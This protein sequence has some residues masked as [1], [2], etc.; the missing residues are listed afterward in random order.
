MK[1]KFMVSCYMSLLCFGLFAQTQ[2]TQVEYFFENDLGFGENA[3]I[4]ISSGEDIMTTIAMVIPEDI[5]AGPHRLNLRLGD[6]DNHWSHTYSFNIE[7]TLVK[8]EENKIVAGEYF[9]NNDPGHY[10][11]IDFTVNPTAVEIE[12][13][14]SAQLNTDLPLGRHKL[15]GRLLDAN[16][17]WSHTFRENIDVV[18]DNGEVKIVQIEYFFL[19]DPTFGDAEKAEIT[20]SGED[21]TQLFRVD[22]PAGPYNFEDVLYVRVKDSRGHWSQTSILNEVDES[23]R[24]ETFFTDNIITVYPNPVNDV[25]NISGLGEGQVTVII[26]DQMGRTIRSIAKGV[27]SIDLKDLP[28]GTYILKMIT[29]INQYTFQI[30]K[31]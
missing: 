3:K 5:I 4:S 23:L 11:A 26:Y 16:G 13:T 8:P 19:T 6:G 31:R 21:V 15:Y 20:E 14:I 17:K 7:V 10:F 27:E 18:K 2:I 25:L 29:Q 1:N 30:L 28:T 12:Q 22:Y 24:E 9:I